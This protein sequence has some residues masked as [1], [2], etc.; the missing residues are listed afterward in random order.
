MKILASRVA[1]HIINLSDHKL[2][3]NKL[4]LFLRKKNNSFYIDDREM[5]NINLF[6]VAHEHA[7]VLK[8][9]KKTNIFIAFSMQDTVLLK[10]KACKR[11]RRTGSYFA[12][13]LSLIHIVVSS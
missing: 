2:Q 10:I 4:C 6:K 3:P 13:Y 8:E 9:K 12:W 7:T 1:E 5:T 11:S